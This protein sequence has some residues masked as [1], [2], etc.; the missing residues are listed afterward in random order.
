MDF[1]F[2]NSFLKNM[3]PQTQKI[4]P[5]L[6]KL[7][8]PLPV[9][10]DPG[11]ISSNKLKGKAALITGGDSG[12]GRAVA[13]AYAKE[14]ADISIVYFNE[15]DD[16][17]ETK[18]IVES[19]GRKC[20]LISG[21][22]SD[23]DFCKIAV[24]QTLNKCGRLDILINNAAVQYVQNSIEDITAA[25]LEKTFKTNVFSIFYLCKAAV[26]HLKPGSAIINTASVTAYKGNKTL[27]DYSSAKGA[28]VTFTRSLA[29]SLCSKHIRVNAIAPGPIWTP[30]IPSSITADEVAQF[31][32]ATPIGRPG[33]PV[34]LAPA[35]VFLASEDSSYVNGS[36]IHVNGGN[37]MS[38]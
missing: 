22:I 21:D 1:E 18:R 9:F 10:D 37:F 29:L 25:Q 11:Y 34:E 24:Q 30:L 17:N 35:Y 32:T 33:Q 8:D 36:V 23:E 16:A 19:L 31:G 5:G 14:G 27:I 2:T 6:E 7:M 38:N 3:P 15:H 4:N 28:V 20:I 13:C 26:P 12:I